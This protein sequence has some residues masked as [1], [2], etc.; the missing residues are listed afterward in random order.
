MTELTIPLTLKLPSSTLQWLSFAVVKAKPD[1]CRHDGLGNDG[2]R[3]HKRALVIVEPAGAGETTRIQQ[4]RVEWLRKS[5]SQ[6]LWKSARK[7]AVRL[8]TGVLC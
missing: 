2:S 7:S 1:R 8:S 5:L 3:F 6:N 4:E